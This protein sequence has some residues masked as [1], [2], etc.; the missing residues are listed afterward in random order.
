MGNRPGRADGFH[1]ATGLRFER[2]L[3]LDPQGRLVLVHRH[4]AATSDEPARSSERV[5]DPVR[6]VFEK[7]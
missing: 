6:I 7:R 1:Q 3:T 5:L 4:P 2:S